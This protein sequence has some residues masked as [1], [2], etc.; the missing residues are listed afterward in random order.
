MNNITN[1]TNAS[2][3]NITIYDP[4]QATTITITYNEIISTFGDRIMTAILLCGAILVFQSFLTSLVKRYGENSF[5]NDLNE[6]VSG[7][8]LVASLYLLAL[9]IIWKLGLNV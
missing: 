4:T 9:G 1:L 8:G 6:F 3:A 2:F 7:M 5:Y